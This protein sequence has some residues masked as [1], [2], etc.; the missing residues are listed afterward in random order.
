MRRRTETDAAWQDAVQ[1]YRTLYGED[2]VRAKPFESAA[3]L[4]KLD[5]CFSLYPPLCDLLAESISP[6]LQGTTDFDACQ[7]DLTARLQDYLT[8]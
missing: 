7:A 4:E 6:Y 1:N 2:A 3:A 5:G 8:A